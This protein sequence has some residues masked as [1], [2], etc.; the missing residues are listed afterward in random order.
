MSDIAV[1]TLKIRASFLHLTPW[2][3]VCCCVFR[4]E[5]CLF[6]ED[7]RSTFF[8]NFYT[9]LPNYDALFWEISSRCLCNF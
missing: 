2:Y 4:T 1:T 6:S 9:C 8:R 7:G 3:G 5:E